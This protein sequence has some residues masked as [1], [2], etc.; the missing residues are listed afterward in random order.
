M[1]TLSRNA[2]RSPALS[3]RV[4]TFLFSRQVWCHLHALLDLSW[5]SFEF[6]LFCCIKVFFKKH[7]L[8]LQKNPL[9]MSFQRQYYWVWFLIWPRST[10]A[11]SM[12]KTKVLHVQY[13]Q[14]GITICCFVYPNYG[15]ISL[16]SQYTMQ[17]FHKVQRCVIEQTERKWSESAFQW[18]ETRDTRKSVTTIYAHITWNFGFTLVGFR[19]VFYT[20]QRRTPMSI[21]AG[22]AVIVS[23][24]RHTKPKCVCRQ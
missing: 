7:V 14:R 1:S 13:N 15:Q 17:P 20:S 2:Q 21:P 18:C 4:F 12:I 24:S 19:Y 3:T 11:L 10:A 5:F 9:S 8:H 6:T 22:V 23:N 16:E